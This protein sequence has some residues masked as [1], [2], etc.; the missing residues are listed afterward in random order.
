MHL[1]DLQFK[2]HLWKK[3]LKQQFQ[4][5]SGPN[6]WRP[7]VAIYFEKHCIIDGLTFVSKAM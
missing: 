4:G 3:L 2:V 7:L 1:F 5:L 6:L